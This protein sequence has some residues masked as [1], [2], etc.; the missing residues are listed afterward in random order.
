MLLAILSIIALLIIGWYFVS[1]QLM[2]DAGE[3][4]VQA[5]AGLDRAH[6]Q[7]ED[8]ARQI[9]ENYRGESQVSH[10]L[11]DAWQK[12]MEINVNP[13]EADV[14]SLRL[15]AKKQA[16]LGEVLEAWLQQQSPEVEADSPAKQYPLIKQQIAEAI[17]YYNREVDHYNSR[18]QQFPINMLSFTEKAAYPIQAF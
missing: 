6:R 5:W 10:Q 8:L 3:Q 7:R 11:K 13:G 4:V 17:R 16:V 14:R 12:I 18:K 9:L 1:H 15:Y 2:A